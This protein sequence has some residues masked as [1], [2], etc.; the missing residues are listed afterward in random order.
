MSTH[1]YIHTFQTLR[2]FRKSLERQQWR[3][4]KSKKKEKG[5]KMAIQE[6]IKERQF[7]FPE[8]SRFWSER[9]EEEKKYKKL[10]LPPYT[11]H[12]CDKTTID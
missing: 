5:K 9:M 7:P 4:E 3:G 11:L 6:E 8:N 1:T 2:R 12:V 10:P